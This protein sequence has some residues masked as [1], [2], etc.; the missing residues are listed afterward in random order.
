MEKSSA[1]IKGGPFLLNYGLRL[2]LKIILFRSVKFLP[3]ESNSQ[4]MLFI[5]I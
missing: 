1:K 3:T 5:L 2:L 4:I